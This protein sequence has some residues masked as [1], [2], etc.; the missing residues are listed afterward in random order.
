MVTAKQGRCHE[1]VIVDLHF[2]TITEQ[3]AKQAHLFLWK[4]DLSA[5]SIVGVGDWMG[6]KAHGSHHLAGPPHLVWEV[7]WVT[8]HLGTQKDS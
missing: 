4:N 3:Q 7:G 2:H 1:C 6:E 8:Y 5:G